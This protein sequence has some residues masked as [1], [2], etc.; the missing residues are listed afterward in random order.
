MPTSQNIQSAIGLAV[1]AA[2]ALAGYLLFLRPSYEDLLAAEQRAEGALAVCEL[3]NGDCAAERAQ[4]EK[5]H[6]RVVD[7]AP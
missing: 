6:R 2:L 1:V 7:R 3:S 4:L 5:A